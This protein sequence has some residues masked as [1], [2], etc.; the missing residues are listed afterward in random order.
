MGRVTESAGENLSP[1]RSPDRPGSAPCQGTRHSPAARRPT[2]RRTRPLR[3]LALAHDSDLESRAELSI[4]PR[5]ATCRA[6]SRCECAHLPGSLS[7]AK[8]LRRRLQ[9]NLSSSCCPSFESPPSP[10]G[11]D[12][13]NLM[14]RAL[15][16]TVALCSAA[17]NSPVEL[18]PAAR[19]QRPE[20]RLAGPPGRASSRDRH[21]AVHGHEWT[22]DEGMDGAAPT[23]ASAGSPRLARPRSGAEVRQPSAATAR[24]HASS[25]PS[26]SGSKST[27]RCC[28]PAMARKA[29][30]RP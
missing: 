6:G 7:T 14:R 12:V 24:A 5:P 15:V 20:S 19:A 9:Q 13:L 22:T 21:S 30:R 2:H 16:G 10:R 18:L 4:P 26:D 23:V 8:P 27:V 1:G 25:S 3:P 17:G 11:G 29:K 28:Q